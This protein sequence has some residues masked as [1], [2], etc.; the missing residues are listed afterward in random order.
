M[1]RQ[2]PRH[3]TA[4][5][6]RGQAAHH[7]LPLL[8]RPG[9]DATINRPSAPTIPRQRPVDNDLVIARS[10]DGLRFDSA[11]TWAEAAGV[12]SVV[13]DAKGRLIAAFQW[14]PSTPP[15]SFDRIAIRTSN[16]QGRTWTEPKTIIVRGLPAGANRPCDPT[17]PCWIKAA[18]GC[19]SPS[20]QATGRGPAATP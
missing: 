5:T 8:G 14:F 11:S 9:I 10:K 7:P 12:P 1:L 15:E 2:R 16:D 6:P 3:K 19:T 4:S 13:R 20:I 17:L 18:F